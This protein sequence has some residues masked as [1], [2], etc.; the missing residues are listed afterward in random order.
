MSPTFEPL[1]LAVDD[2]PLAARLLVHHRPAARP[3]GLVVYVHPFA[4]EMNKSRRMAALQARAL[5]AEG[6][7][8]VQIDLLGCGDS[9][10]D[11]GDARWT[12]WVDDVV[13]AATWLQQQHAQ[14]A[15]DANADADAPPL[16]LW[17][18]RAGCLLAAE[19]GARLAARGQACHF[20]FWQPAPVGK[21]LLQQFLR[22]KAAG[23]LLAGQAKAAMEQLRAELAAG[24]PVEVAGYLLDP[25]LC[26]GLDAAQLQPPQAMPRRP[27]DMA[28]SLDDVPGQPRPRGRCRA[29]SLGQRRLATACPGRPRPALLADRRDRGRARADRGRRRRPVRRRRSRA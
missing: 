15:G 19:A 5:A 11:F 16:W 26:A 7:A 28:R 9:A 27:S 6:F 21:L 4:E 23:E 2:T 3:R 22:L 10:G 24:R 8:V 18:L 14:P 12:R 1:F 29:R 13:A 25:A 17:G 20:L